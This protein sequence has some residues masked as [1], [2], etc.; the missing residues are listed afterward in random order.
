MVSQMFTHK[1]HCVIIIHSR[2]ENA[3]ILFGFILF[4]Y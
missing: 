3:K 2:Y 4:I 1:H